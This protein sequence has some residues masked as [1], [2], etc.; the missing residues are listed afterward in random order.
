LEELADATPDGKRKQH[1]ELLTTVPLLIIGDL[2]MH[3]L[4]P[5]DL[6]QGSGNWLL[7]AFAPLWLLLERTSRSTA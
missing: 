6:K 7:P 3:K 2:G 4:P 5:K 1:M